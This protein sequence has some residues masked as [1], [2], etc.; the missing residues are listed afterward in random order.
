M[1]SQH[2][3][4]V[5]KADGTVSI[6]KIESDDVNVKTLLN[7]DDVETFTGYHHKLKETIVFDMIADSSAKDKQL[8]LN[9]RAT[10]S[11]NEYLKQEK[12]NQIFN[13]EI[14]GDIAIEFKT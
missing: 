4:V 8:P 3:I 2:K 14:F 1:T 6:H 9:N 10:Y 12:P 11:Y 7:A 5:W 13:K